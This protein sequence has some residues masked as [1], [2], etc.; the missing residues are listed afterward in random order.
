MIIDD[1]YERVMNGL[2]GIFQ[3]AMFN[4]TGGFP[5]W[6]LKIL[7][8]KPHM[9]AANWG[10]GHAISQRDWSEQRLCFFQEWIGQVN[11]ICQHGHLQQ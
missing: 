6:W 8:N 2:S 9:K 11:Q 3:L 4:N 7:E 10:L 5:K 1:V